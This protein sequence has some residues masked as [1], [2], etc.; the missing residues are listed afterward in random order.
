LATAPHDSRPPAQLSPARSRLFIDLADTGPLK[1]VPAV[2]I[3]REQ[4]RDQA[5]RRAGQWDKTRPLGR[6]AVRGH[7]QSILRDLGLPEEYLG[8]T[9]VAAASAFWRPQVESI[10]HQRRL[11]LLPHCLRDSRHCPAQYDQWGLLC[12]DCG[13]CRLSDLRAMAQAKGYQVLIAEGS[14]T[15]VDV[16]LRGQADALLGAACLNSLEKALDKILL[17]GIPCM[18]VPL[19]TNACRDTSIDEDWV[20]EMIDVPYRAGAAPVRTYL[21]LLRL[22]TRI[23]EPAELARLVP[24]LRGGPSLAESN[25]DGLAGLDPIAATEA[26]AHD[27]LGR[28]GKHFRPFITLAAYDAA[29]GGHGAGAD[30]AEAVAGLPDSVRRIALAIEVFHKASLVHD[31]IEDDDPFRYGQP[32]LHRRFGTPIAVNVGDYLIGLGYR[33][34]AAQRAGAPGEAIADILG[35]LAGAHTKLCEG[36][37][38][39]LAWRSAPDK[40]IAPL[41]ALKI[42]ALKTAPAFEAALCAG[43]RLAGPIEKLREPA[44]RFARHLGVAYQVLNDLE[45]WHLEQPNKR[46]T[47]TDVL[48]GRP[49]VL[50]AFALE[51]LSPIDRR[52]LE[53]LLAEAN[54]EPGDVVDEVRTLY[55]R[56]GVYRRARDL[57]AKQRQRAHSIA[58]GLQPAPLAHL[59]HYLA[60]TI[61]Q[62]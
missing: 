3:E 14:P 29:T 10:P 38:A 41:E 35:Q 54:R 57:V 1:R 4:I 56:A 5:A 7:A 24:R 23:F 22:A 37:G 46:S 19:L 17:A 30:G 15:V 6:E 43:L 27:F 31:D 9:M 33:L 39:E 28:G 48:G 40:Q 58:D 13:A 2:R 32:A 44:A 20:R 8:W 12:Q 60:D 55:E 45:D 61:L 59:L 18:A 36:Q 42:Y 25:G 52:R 47:G 62:G 51:N 50:W 21:H 49:T 53:T 16:I 11:L 26:V 34:V